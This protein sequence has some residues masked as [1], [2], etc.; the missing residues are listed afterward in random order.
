[1]PFNSDTYHANKLRKSAW[2][3]LADART[4]RDRIRAGEAYDWEREITLPRLLR[5]ARDDMRLSVFYRNLRR[6]P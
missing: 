5:T 6:K 3:A 2:K 4:L 1:M